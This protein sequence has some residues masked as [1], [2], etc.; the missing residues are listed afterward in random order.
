MHSEYPWAWLPSTGEPI[1]LCP[2]I[3]TI[4]WRS[5]TVITSTKCHKKECLTT[6]T[7]YRVSIHPSYMPIFTA[8]CKKSTCMSDTIS[9]PLQWQRNSKTSLKNSKSCL[10]CLCVFP[11]MILLGLGNLDDPLVIEFLFSLTFIINL[12]QIDWEHIK[13]TILNINRERLALRWILIKTP[14]ID[15]VYLIID[16]LND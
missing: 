5:A 6:P 14:S 7:A 8:K 13:R 4:C 16:V 15:L 3:K 9:L 12:V 11:T 2:N 10:H 1:R